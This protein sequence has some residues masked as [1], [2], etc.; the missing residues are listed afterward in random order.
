MSSPGYARSWPTQ[1]VPF[2]ARP[3]G[4]WPRQQPCSRL[5][6][7]LGRGLAYGWGLAFFILAFVCLIGMRLAVRSSAGL[8]VALLLGVGLLLGLSM[9]RAALSR[10]GH[11]H[12]PSL[13][14]QKHG[15]SPVAR[16]RCL[17]D[18][19]QDTDGVGDKIDSCRRQERARGTESSN[20]FSDNGIR[21]D[22]SVPTESMR[23]AATSCKGLANHGYRPS[24]FHRNIMSGQT[25]TGARQGPTLDRWRR[26][27]RNSQ[28][29]LRWQTEPS[30]V[31]CTLGVL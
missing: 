2:S 16:G 25:M 5:G 9:S 17:R 15:T 12:V 29:G 18:Q 7:Y 28:K 19:Q 13:S 27:R 21:L 6:S 10:S 30:R 11:G 3:C 23:S 8:S 20:R 4:T 1:P 26:A 14:E 22:A 31:S 24:N